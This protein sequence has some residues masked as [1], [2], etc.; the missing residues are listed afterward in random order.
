MKKLVTVCSIMT[1]L[2]MLKINDIQKQPVPNRIV[3]SQPTEVEKFMYHMAQRESDNTAHVVNQFGMLG[4]Y[5]FSPTTIKMLGF[6]ISNAKFLNNPKLQDSVMIANLRLNNQE[7][8]SIIKKYE[9]KLVKGIK[10][11]RAGILAA[12]HLA[13]PAH[14]MKF[15]ANANDA[16]GLQDA[17]GTSVRDYLQLFAKHNIK[18]E[19]LL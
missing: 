16:I 11:T 3:M 6:N 8:N 14:V 5:Q 12:A 9:G 15:F 4:K 2:M 1:V 18:N 13:G 7:L 19:H 10:I 17:N